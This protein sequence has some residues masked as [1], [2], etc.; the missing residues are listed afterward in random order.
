MN[1]WITRAGMNGGYRGPG[2]CACCGRPV[3]HSILTC[4]DCKAEYREAQGSQHEVMKYLITS[5]V[6]M[7]RS[8]D[9]FDKNETVFSD[10]GLGMGGELSDEGN[11]F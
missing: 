10:L 11:G 8:D 6:T 5:A 1:T 4:V 7:R 9:K 3:M 2:S